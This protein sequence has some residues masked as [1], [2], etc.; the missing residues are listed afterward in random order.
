MAD[1]AG[2]VGRGSLGPPA[3]ER[4]VRR[5][6]AALVLAAGGIHLWLYFDFFHAV[7][8]VGTLFIVNAAFGVFGGA[9]LLVTG[10]PW[11][12]A[13]GIAYSAGTLAGF[14]WSVYQGLFGYVESLRGPWQ[15]AAGGVEVAALVVLT[16]LLVS[17]LR[18]DAKRPRE[19]QRPGSLVTLTKRRAD[20]E[21][22]RWA[23]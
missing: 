22:R 7:H 17:A 8:V 21:G 15:E 13:T 11:A 10:R 14:F 3:A 16:P 4:A 5:F 1:R 18:R 6:G 12:L 2:S 20:R 23:H 19:N 9:V